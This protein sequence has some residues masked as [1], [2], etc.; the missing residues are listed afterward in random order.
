MRTL[1]NEEGGVVVERLEAFDDEARTYTYSTVRAPFPV[2]G[3]RSALTVREAP[4][5]HGARV[6]WSG[7]FTPVEVTD[8]EAVDLFHGICADGLAALCRTPGQPAAGDC[9]PSPVR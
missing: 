6:E 5:G 2:T 8:Q 3:Y 9:T 1:T 4:D 7:T